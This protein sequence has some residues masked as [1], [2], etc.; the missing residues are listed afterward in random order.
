MRTIKLEAI[1]LLAL[2]TSCKISEKNSSEAI[3]ADYTIPVKGSFQLSLS[4]NITTGYC[5]VWTNRQSV[6]IVDTFNYQYKADHP[7]RIGSSAT[8]IWNF[9]GKE[10]GLDTIV[11]EYKRVWE[12]I[13]PVISKKIVVRVK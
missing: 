6:S 11:L 2:L 9:R 13:P 4:S 10:P 3:K 7:D 8:E 1:L 5:W 12:H